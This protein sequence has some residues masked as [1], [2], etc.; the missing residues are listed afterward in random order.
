[1]QHLIRRTAPVAVLMLAL[2]ACGGGGD[3][4]GE[5]TSSATPTATTPDKVPDVSQEGILDA[6]G[7]T[8]RCLNRVSTRP[9]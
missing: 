9:G 7:L 4:G 2:A 8:Q 5:Q 3:D 6:A 1:M